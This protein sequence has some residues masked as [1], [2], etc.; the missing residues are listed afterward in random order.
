M[1]VLFGPECISI[2]NL[3]SMFL[4]HCSQF[5][6]KLQRIREDGASKRNNNRVGEACMGK[7][8]GAQKSKGV[9]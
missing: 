9:E 6:R 3:H 1:V 8:G 4:L 7:M 5:Y 2:F